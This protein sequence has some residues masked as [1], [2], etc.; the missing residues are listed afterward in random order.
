MEYGYIHEEIPIG[1]RIFTGDLGGSSSILVSDRNWEIF[2][3]K[4][5]TQIGNGFDTLNCTNYA[6]L[7]CMETYE[8]CVYGIIHDHADRFAAFVSG[9]TKIGNTFSKTAS[10]IKQFGVVPE[11]MWPKTVT[12]IS[13]EA[14]MAKPDEIVFK[15]GEKSLELY[16]FDSMYV[17]PEPDILYEALG[18][19]PLRVAVHAWEKP[20]NGIYQRTEKM[21]NHAVMLFRG[22][23]GKTFTIEDHYDQAGNS[24]KT[25]AW[26]FRFWAAQ[27]HTLEKKSMSRFKISKQEDGKG[28]ALLCEAQNEDEL[29]TLCKVLGVEL[30]IM[31][32]KIEWSF[33]KHDSTY[34]NI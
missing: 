10:A 6:L 24:K 33:V 7:N 3:P 4:Y 29:K 34:K 27:L 20:V 28:Y 5:E 9:N 30:P 15:E 14:Y 19:G 12:I 25:L 31:D 32:G 23:Y 26:N 17:V 8:K 13:W 22:E 11:K 21:A 18:H 2:L 1:T 16:D